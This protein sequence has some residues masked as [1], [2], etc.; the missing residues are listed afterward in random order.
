M[1]QNH[2]CEKQT[3][4]LELTNQSWNIGKRTQSRER[5]I[6]ACNKFECRWRTF[7]YVSRSKVETFAVI[8][9]QTLSQNKRYQIVP[10]A[11]NLKK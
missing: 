3:K 10:F 4:I 1:F 5:V 2:D 8:V 9:A 6:R 7:T 11:A